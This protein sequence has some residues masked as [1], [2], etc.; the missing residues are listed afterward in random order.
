MNFGFPSLFVRT[1]VATFFS[2]SSLS[3]RFV[4]C[5]SY[6]CGTAGV[7]VPATD[8]ADSPPTWVYVVVGLGIVI[9]EFAFY[10]LRPL[11]FLVPLP[12]LLSR[13]SLSLTPN[14]IL[15]LVRPFVAQSSSEPSPDFTS[16]IVVRERSTKSSSS[17]TTL[18]RFVSFS[19]HL[20]PFL[21]FRNSN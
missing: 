7:C 4:R 10:P 3:F 12:R 15:S 17:S 20:L 2:P 1:R 14:H 21:S 9:G 18:S 13:P 5:I 16:S 11:R 8:S 19:P 6:N